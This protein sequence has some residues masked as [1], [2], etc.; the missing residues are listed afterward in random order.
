MTIQMMLRLLRAALVVKEQGS[1]AAW[2]RATWTLLWD[3]VTSSARTHTAGREEEE[4]SSW[5]RRAGD[6]S[7]VLPDV[8][9]QRR[10]VS[11]VCCV[12]TAFPVKTWDFSRPPPPGPG[13]SG[14]AALLAAS[15]APLW[16]LD[17]A[18]VSQ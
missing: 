1:T 13:L 2:P 6:D 9:M 11:P 4:V 15:V 12:G 3:T 14:A 16:E 7:P 5:T 17:N 8:R 10:S 18:V